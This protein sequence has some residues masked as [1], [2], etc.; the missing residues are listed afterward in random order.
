MLVKEERQQ[1]AIFLLSPSCSLSS[2]PSIHSRWGKDLGIFDSGPCLLWDSFGPLGKLSQETIS[3]GHWFVLQA[4]PSKLGF[5]W[6]WR[7]IHQ[8]GETHPKIKFCQPLPASENTRPTL[9]SSKNY[10]AGLLTMEQPRAHVRWTPKTMMPPC[11]SSPSQPKG[12]NSW[13]QPKSNMAVAAE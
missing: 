9:R 5:K 3:Q 8:K 13:P 12:T 10:R 4:L 7:L 1:L 6:W 2:Q 11:R